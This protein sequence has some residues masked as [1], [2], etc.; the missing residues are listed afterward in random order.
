MTNFVWWRINHIYKMCDDFTPLTFPCSACCKPAC[1]EWAVFSWSV[2]TVVAA[3]P[4]ESVKVTWSNWAVASKPVPRTLKLHHR[5]CTK[6]WTPV[7]PK[8]SKAGLG[9]LNTVQS[10]WTGESF[11]VI[12]KNHLYCRVQAASASEHWSPVYS[13]IWLMVCPNPTKFDTALPWAP[14][15]WSR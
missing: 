13:N 5:F 8:F 1:L 10:T 2:V 11:V 3:S 6:S 14:Q 12:L 7:Y 15:V 4:S 9:T